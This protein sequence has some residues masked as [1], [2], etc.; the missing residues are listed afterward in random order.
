[1]SSFEFGLSS[2][3]PEVYCGFVVHRFSDAQT[4]LKE[5]RLA[6]DVAPDELTC[7]AVM[8]QAP[9]LPFLPA[10]W[11]GKE[12]LVLAMCYCGNVADGEAATATMREIGNPVAV[13]A[14]P[15]P[16]VD[17]QQ[18]FDPWLFNAVK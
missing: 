14:G 7:W 12:V 16:F 8:R 6:L 5:Y 15:L 17:W 18:A 1:V 9:P 4:V 13:H 11:H 2:A 10:A 3:G